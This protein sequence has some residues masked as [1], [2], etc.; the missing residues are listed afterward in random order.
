MNMIVKVY[1]V[2]LPNQIY[3]NGFSNHLPKTM[4]DIA[5]IIYKTDSLHFQAK[6]NKAI[7]QNAKRKFHMG[8]DASKN[9]YLYST[10][11]G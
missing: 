1:E 3:Q 8:L 5:L 10:F 7:V 11:A 6:R 2:L 9:I 4:V